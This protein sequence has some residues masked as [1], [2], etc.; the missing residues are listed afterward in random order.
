MY[1][2]WCF[3]KFVMLHH[4]LAYHKKDLALNR[5]CLDIKK[6]KLQKCYQTKIEVQIMRQIFF[7]FLIFGIWAFVFSKKKLWLNIGLFIY[8]FIYLL[9][10]WRNFAQKESLWVCVFVGGVFC[11]LAL[12]TKATKARIL[13]LDSL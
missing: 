3:F 8:L 7:N 1:A 9:H 12:P 11:L 13:C 5:T 10:F 6:N 2:K 4:W